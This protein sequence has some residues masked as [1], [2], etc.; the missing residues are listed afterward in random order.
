LPTLTVTLTPTQAG[1]RALRTPRNTDR[2]DRRSQMLGKR[3]AKRYI[4]KR[5]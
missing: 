4:L 1:W 2:I 5:R 3:P